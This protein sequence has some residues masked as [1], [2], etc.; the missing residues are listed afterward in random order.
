MVL[1]VGTV[2]AKESTKIYATFG[3][4]TS[5]SYSDNTYSWTDSQ[6]RMWLFPTSGLNLDVTK[7]QKLH[8]KVT[9]KTGGGSTGFCVRIFTG[10]AYSTPTASQDYYSST[11]ID[12]DLT[13]V[14][15]TINRIDI[16]GLGTSGFKILASDVY[17]WGEYEAM[18]IT[19]TLNSSTTKTDPF[20]WYT[21][22]DGSTKTEMSSGDLY[23]NQFGSEGHKEILSSVGSNLGYK[24]GFFDI[25]GYDNA[26]VNI[27]TY[28]DSRD[29]QIRLL[30]ATGETSTTNFVMDANKAGATT[31]SLSGLTTRW[32]A[33][34]YSN[35]SSE[36]GQ[37]ITSVVFSKD[38][39]AASTT[40]FS[41]AASASSTVNYDR[42]FKAGKVYTICL[43][44]AV[45]KADL[46]GTVYKFSEVTSDGVVRFTEAN[47]PN[48][49]TPYLFVPNADCTPFNGVTYAIVASADKGTMNSGVKQTGTDNTWWNF[50]GTLVHIDDVKT[51]ADDRPAYGW[52]ASTGNFVKV[53]TSVS[54][55]AFRGYILAP[56]GYSGARLNVIFD[57]EATGIQSANGEGF[58]V[59]GSNAMYNLQGQR[60]SENHKGLVIKN[61]KKV[62]IK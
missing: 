32:I 9:D 28:S 2:S 62:A 35:N 57:D 5:A 24:N 22:T 42:E 41:I 26:T 38:Y 14:S 10:D 61:G 59:N 53:G 39:N 43:P 18:E 47:T 1:A 20:Q 37:N 33:G 55:D 54:I 19:T 50:Q 36:N 8:V 13:S 58:M 6:N 45:R 23:K 51:T 34:I 29:S 11:E 3:D 30:Q 21:S 44:F 60:V 25:T 7:Y 17:L 48:A 27:T 49:Y 16:R 52:D 12:F 31:T 56:S 40:E 15:G 4:C 46:N